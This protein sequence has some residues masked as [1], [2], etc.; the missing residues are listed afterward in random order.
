[1]Q[2]E[3]ERLKLHETMIDLN[4]TCFAKCVKAV[5]TTRLSSSEN[6][7]LRAC[8]SR[9]VDCTGVVVERVSKARF[10]EQ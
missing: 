1:V 5:D 9:F 2:Q 8:A 4:T 3:Q 6:S 7:C 10:I